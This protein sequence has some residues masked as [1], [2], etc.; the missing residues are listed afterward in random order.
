M[1]KSQGSMLQECGSIEAY[2]TRGWV[3]NPGSRVLYSSGT[4]GP[5]S[6]LPSLQITIPQWIEGNIPLPHSIKY[7]HCEGKSLLEM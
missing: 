3:P 6:G 5:D 4:K 7:S 1:I 2:G